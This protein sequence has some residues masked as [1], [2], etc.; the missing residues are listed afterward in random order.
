MDYCIVCERK[1]Q[2]LDDNICNVCLAL[3]ASHPRGAKRY[4]M[5][6]TINSRTRFNERMKALLGKD[7]K[8]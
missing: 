3:Q 8:R 6:R 1:S 2:N 5:L 4:G 7:S